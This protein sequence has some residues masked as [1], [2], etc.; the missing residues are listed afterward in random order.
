MNR[1]SEKIVDALGGID[2]RY[3]LECLPLLFAKPRHHLRN[4]LLAAACLAICALAVPKVWPNLSEY[5]QKPSPIVQPVEPDDPSREEADPP[6]P[7]LPML[8]LGT[9]FVGQGQNIQ[10]TQG[11]NRVEQLQLGGLRDMDALPETLPVYQNAYPENEAGMYVGW[12]PDFEAMEATL[13]EAAK[14]IGL[15]AD[16]IMR[17]ITSVHTGGATGSW[18]SVDVQGNISILLQTPLL[19]PE[20]C[21]NETAES[22]ENAAAYLLQTYGDQLEMEQPA[23]AVLGGSGIENRSYEICIYD[24][25]GTQEEQLVSQAF[26]SVV[27]DLEDSTGITHLTVNRRQ[28]GEKLGDYPILSPDE[29]E[30]L[31]LEGYGMTSVWDIP[32]NLEV[33]AMSVIY[34]NM[35]WFDCYM[36]F[37]QFL[38]PTDT[39]MG[40]IQAYATIYLPA[41]G[42]TYISDNRFW[43]TPDAVLTFEEKV[44]TAPDPDKVG[45][46]AKEAF[47]AY[48]QGNPAVLETY[49]SYD[50]KFRASRWQDEDVAVMKCDGPLMGSTGDSQTFLY[51]YSDGRV[52]FGASGH[53]SPE[54]VDHAEAI[55]RMLTERDPEAEDYEAY[56]RESFAR[57]YL[58]HNLELQLLPS[59][60]GGSAPDWDALSKYILLL[61]KPAGTVTAEDFRALVEQYVEADYSDG[62]SA[63]MTYDNGVYGVTSADATLDEIY[64]RLVKAEP[65]EDGAY[66][67]TFDGFLLPYGEVREGYRNPESQNMQLLVKSTGFSAESLEWGNIQESILQSTWGSPLSLEEQG[68]EV[69]ERVTVTFRLQ[70]GENPM[71]Y[72]SCRRGFR[73]VTK[74]GDDWL[75]EN[76]TKNGTEIRLFNG[77]NYETRDSHWVEMDMAPPGPDELSAESEEDE[78]GY[79]AYTNR[80]LTLDGVSGDLAWGEAGL[81]RYEDGLLLQ[82]YDSGVCAAVEDGGG[83]LLISREKGKRVSFT[84]G[85][86]QRHAGDLVVQI[87]S[88]GTAITLADASDLG[89]CLTAVYRGEDGSLYVEASENWG[90]A[91]LH[92]YLYHVSD[93]RLTACATEGGNGYSDRSEAEAAAEQAR[94][95][96][97][98]AARENR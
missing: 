29:A 76:H 94:L 4:W 90:M 9:E 37:Y 6:L 49:G 20:G 67:A 17:G 8:T 85:G 31:L 56:L 34:L 54:T 41:V 50:L 47:I 84:S 68:F 66:Q 86:T 3:V 18:I 97:I 62:P 82:L 28:L 1:K 7:D 22:A 15:D 42:P 33:E 2:D 65:L 57:Y 63:C 39:A 26:R 11:D 80:Y 16:E 77:R 21:G 89:L 5:F 69:A 71:Q 95:D 88:D 35:S 98:Y 44:W 64:Y 45:G 36:P 27:F 23:A 91:D 10:D 81:Y 25:A 96:A 59:F 60:D 70:D 55:R 30:R 19:L 24:S 72:L 52:E 40:G 78:D 51:Y 83:Y 14:R 93:G 75:I 74:W 46:A 48:F 87:A 79:Y 13:R 12:E 38:V 73:T 92:V 43:K 58:D 32:E 61:T 53:W